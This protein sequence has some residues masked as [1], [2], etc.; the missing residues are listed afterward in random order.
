MTT[1]TKPDADTAPGAGLDLVELVPL[2]VGRQQPGAWVLDLRLLYDPSTGNVHGVG[3][4]IHGGVEG[5]PYEVNASGHVF[6]VLVLGR[7][8]RMVN[9]SGTV[10]QPP[11][12]VLGRF[13][14]H[15]QVDQSWAGTGSYKFFGNSVDD[16]PVQRLG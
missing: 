16:V 12:L 14:A 6:T 7:P 1:A 5:R 13:E 11:A 4:I 10:G 8:V 3:S 15:L 2:R 9:L